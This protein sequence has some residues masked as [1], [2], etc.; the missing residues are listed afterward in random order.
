ML[1]QQCCSVLQYVATT[2]FQCVGK[3]IFSPLPKFAKF[4]KISLTKFEYVKI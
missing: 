3:I 1:Q 4:T 2:M